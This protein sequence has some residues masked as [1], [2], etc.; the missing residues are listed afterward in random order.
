MKMTKS[1]FSAALI[2]SIALA[3]GCASSPKGK[4]YLASDGDGLIGLKSDENPPGFR[5]Y[6]KCKQQG[7]R[8]ERNFRLNEKVITALADK[9][10]K[11]FKSHVYYNEGEGPVITSDI[12]VKDGRIEWITVK[13]TSLEIDYRFE[14]TG[15]PKTYKL[16][17]DGDRS[18]SFDN[19][20]ELVL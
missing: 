13:L 18:M 15:D 12:G 5:I 16:Y 11:T 3:T 14:S 8:P 2:V 9:A 6:M 1:F 10:Q 4:R 20:C 7:L 19:V 17:L